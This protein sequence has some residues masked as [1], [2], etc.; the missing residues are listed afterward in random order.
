MAYMMP[1][2]LMGQAVQADFSPIQNAL[3]QYNKN[4][5][6]NAT[7][8]REYAQLAELQ[9][10]H[11]IQNALARDQYGLAV[12]TADRQDELAPLQQQH[13]Q[14]QTQNLLAHGRYYDAASKFKYADAPQAPQRQ[15]IIGQREDGSLYQMDSGE[16]TVDTGEPRRESR[17]LG[18]TNYGSPGG[19][20]SKEHDDYGPMGR[21]P[22]N[23]PGIVVVPRSGGTDLQATRAMQGQRAA[24]AMPEQD[25]QR[26]IEGQ[27][28]QQLWTS[29][30][31]RPPRAGHM[32]DKQG[33]EVP[34]GPLSNSADSQERKDRAIKNMQ[35]QIDEA[36]KTLL[37]SWNITR[38]VAKGLDDLGTAGRFVQP[39]SMEKLNAAY[40]QYQEGVLQTVYALSGKQ[41]TNKEMEAF[42]GL[43]MPRPGESDFR[44]QEKTQ[45]LKKMLSTLQS[46]VKR[47]MVYDDAERVA[48]SDAAAADLGKM[49]GRAPGAGESPRNP[50]ADRLRNKYGLE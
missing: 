9:R 32:Y 28:N 1:N 6:F 30:Y 27:R 3:A 49:Q 8:D 22:V 5:Q 38:S 37:G 33:R 24:D 50:A 20:V 14:A 15:P 4:M 45:R 10:Q 25:R 36:E 29:Y 16:G 17:V 11:G 39:Q 26:F 31:N 44:I 47:G 46:N 48:I 12:R 35:R 21:N 34:V 41:T 42:L 23:V 18:S 13:V 40:G 7:T 2:F 43:Y 19:V